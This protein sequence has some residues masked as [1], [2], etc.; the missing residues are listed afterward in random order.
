MK[1]APESYVG[2]ALAPRLFSFA[3]GR[4]TIAALIAM[5]GIAGLGAIS[6]TFIPAPAA[7]GGGGQEFF[8]DFAT[9]TTGSWTTVSGSAATWN[10][11]TENVTISPNS[12]WI[13]NTATDTITQA[14]SARLDNAFLGYQGIVLRADK[15]ASNPAY[16]LRTNIGDSMTLRTINGNTGV[17]DIYSWARTLNSGDYIGLTVSGTGSSTV[18]TLFDFGFTDPG[19]LPDDVSWTA[20]ADAYVVVNSGNW[21]SAPSTYA[22]SGKYTGF[23]S[24]GG[25]GDPVD[26]FRAGDWDG[27]H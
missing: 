25:S 9:D 27:S 14:A 1:P 6:I 24:G 10:S 12:Q 20:A 7:G 17:T 18:F 16:A 21:A 4:R 11:G 8:Q 23:Y 15:N 5:F 3:R 2:P 19:G 26:N 13:Y 22:D